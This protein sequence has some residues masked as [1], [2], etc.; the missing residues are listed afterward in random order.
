MRRT[1]KVDLD[2]TIKIPSKDSNN[3]IAVIQKVKC[4]IVRW[5]VEVYDQDNETV[6]I[7]VILTMVN[8][9]EN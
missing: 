6:A 5:L 3:P 9:S 8:K 7:S 2:N 4:G 1:E